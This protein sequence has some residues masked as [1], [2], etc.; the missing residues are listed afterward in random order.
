MGQVKIVEND[1]WKFNT[2]GK[3]LRNAVPL[4]EAA[5]EDAPKK[6]A[7][8]TF[9]K[10]GTSELERDIAACLAP[11]LSLVDPW[12]C[13]SH[14]MEDLGVDSGGFGRL[15]SQMR[16]RPTLQ[17]VDLQMLFQHPTVRSLATALQSTL[18][19]DSDSESVDGCG[20]GDASL[21]DA[22]MARLEEAPHAVCVECGC[23]GTSYHQ[24]FRLACSYQRLLHQELK[25]KRQEQAEPCVAICLDLPERVAAMIAV[26]REGCAFCVLDPRSGDASM[27]EQLRLS[28]P[29]ALLANRAETSWTCLERCC[30]LASDVAGPA[31]SDYITMLNISLSHAACTTS[32]SKV[33]WISVLLTC[34]CSFDQSP[35]RVWLRWRVPLWMSAP[36]PLSRRRSNDGV[37]ARRHASP[38]RKPVP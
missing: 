5:A 29:H 12:D 36:P 28:K 33:N 23:Q 1:A 22:F 27:L 34:V 11:Q 35:C 7:W 13:N 20:C 31:C 30:K 17:R 18:S 3:L 32:T 21:L 25:Q 4:D 37:G 10:E 15:I 8:E 38:L 26:V 16:S 24:L 6:D 19:E 14:F 9:V 2:S